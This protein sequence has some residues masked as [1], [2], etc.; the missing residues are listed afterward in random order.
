MG[1]CI[2]GKRQRSLV[3]MVGGVLIITVSYLVG[4]ALV[5]SLVCAGLMALVY[6]LLRQGY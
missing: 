5:M 1:Y 2:Y 6:M 4:S 3:P